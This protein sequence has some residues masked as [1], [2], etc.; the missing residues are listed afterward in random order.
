[1]VLFVGARADAIKRN[2]VIDYSGC[3]KTTRAGCTEVST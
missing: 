1:M 3:N 2:L